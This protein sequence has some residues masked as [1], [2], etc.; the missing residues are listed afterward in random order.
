MNNNLETDPLLTD[1]AVLESVT[2]PSGGIGSDLEVTE[3]GTS[4]TTSVTLLQ[5]LKYLHRLKTFVVK[6]GVPDTLF[7]STDEIELYIR[8]HVL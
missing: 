8:F 6:K 7:K 3:G 2:E 5:P 4:V 1:S